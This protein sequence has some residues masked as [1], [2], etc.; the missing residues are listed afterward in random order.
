M[1]SLADRWYYQQWI[2]PPLRFIHFNVVQSLAVFYGSNRTDYYLT[3]G[4]PLLLT[5]SLPFAAAG[6][7][8]ALDRRRQK[9]GSA[10][11]LGPVCPMEMPLALTI[12]I[13]TAVLSLI[14]HKEVRFIYP[15]LPALHALAAEPIARF[16]AP[17]PTP[18]FRGRKLI[19]GVLLCCNVFIAGY[20]SLIHQR[21]VVDVTHFL[22]HEYERNAR[23]ESAMLQSNAPIMKVGF[24]MPCHSTPWQSHL[25]HSGLQGWALTC[26]P[27]LE[28]PMNQ[29][30][31]YHD[32]A[33]VF[34][35]NPS[36]W[37]QTEMQPLASPGHAVVGNRDEK[38]RR[39]W[40]D[41]LVFFEH[42]EPTMRAV[43]NGTS[44][45]ECWRGFNTHFHDDWRRRGDVVVWSRWTGAELGDA[46]PAG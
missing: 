43:L 28:I 13:M 4:L 7:Y 8:R 18:Y 22:R 32:E 15:L 33:D 5:T 40:P 11:S 10:K 37:L 30:G 26:E 19:L 14:A 46:R 6:L 12:I 17:F 44:Y 21:G 3:E 45:Q 39:A 1:A 35:N 9:P 31:A 20:A 29:R 23:S 16:F 41:Y 42:L 36:S 24:L 34:Y 38:D 2:F 25:V 27:P